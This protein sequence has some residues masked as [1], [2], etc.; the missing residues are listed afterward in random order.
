MSE[1]DTSVSHQG[2]QFIGRHRVRDLA[3]IAF[4]EC[5]GQ[6]SLED[7]KLMTVFFEEVSARA[8]CFLLLVDLRESIAP[9][10]EARK[11]LVDW[12]A[13]RRGAT[14]CIGGST[15]VNVVASLLNRAVRLIHGN[16]MPMEMFKIEV[17]AIAWL[18]EKQR[19]MAAAKPV[20]K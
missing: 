20:K 5:H 17:Q 7:A 15:G 9:G 11:W 18:R 19:Q 12:T 10:P 3:G 16:A 6:I 4:V 8:G 14:A 2:W 1:V 13:D